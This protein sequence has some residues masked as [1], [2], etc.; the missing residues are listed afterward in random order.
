MSDVSYERR[1]A[2]GL[3]WKAEK[4]RVLN[5]HGT[6]DWTQKEQRELIAS[7]KVKGYQGHHMKSVDGH[8]SKAGDPRNIQFLT[9]KEH[10]AAH[11]GDYHN[12]TNGYYDPK[13]GKMNSFGRNG[14]SVESK[15]L[16][17][18]LSN[19]QKSYA[20]NKGNK[21]TEAKRQKAKEARAARLA[22]NKQAPK[23]KKPTPEMNAA[24]TARGGNVSDREKAL[25]QMKS[26][27]K[28]SAKTSSA[29]ARKKASEQMKSASKGAPGQNTAYKSKTQSSAKSQSASRTNQNKPKH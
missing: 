25:S 12:N 24:K 5:G 10:L 4:E 19:S 16:S 13:T 23:G 22:S 11:S 26:A 18:P 20:V 1:K 9:R 2:V 14:A 21:L 8:N 6:R 28:T 29:D 27:S 3:A 15:P 17:Q 7:G